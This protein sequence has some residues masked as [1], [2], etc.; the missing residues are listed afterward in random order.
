MAQRSALGKGSAFAEY[1]KREDMD[2]LENANKYEGPTGYFSFAAER[3]IWKDVQEE[4]PEELLLAHGRDIYVHKLPLSVY[5]PYCSGHSMQTLLSKGLVTST[6]SSRPARHMDT[7]VDHLANYLITLQHFFTGAQAASSVEWYSGPFIKSDGLS[8][9]GVKQNVQRLLFNL[10]YPSRVGMQ[11]PFTNFTISLDASKKMLEGDQALIGGQK[12][13][14]LGTYEVEA[15]SFVLALISLLME[16]DSAGAPFTFPIPTLMATAPML[17]DD[18]EIHDQVFKTASKKG[19]FYWLNT[20]VVDPDASFAMCCRINIDRN[21]LAF[22]YGLSKE[23][24]RDDKARFGGIWAI[25]DATGS[26]NATD[27]NLPRIAMEAPNESDFWELYEEKLELVR[28][29]E[30]WLRNRYTTYISRYPG[31]YWAIRTYLP[32]FPQNHFNTIGL[33]GL[34]E[35][36]SILMNKPDLWYEGNRKDWLEAAELMK[37]LVTFAVDHARRWMTETGVPWNVEEVPGESAAPKLALSDARDFARLRDFLPKDTDPIYSTSIAPYYGVVELPDR[38][39]IEAKVQK[40][41]TGGVMM[42]IFLGEEPDPEAL[43][44]LTK[45]LIQTDLVYWSYTPALTVCRACGHTSV[46]IHSTCPRCGSEDVEIWSRIIGYY[47][48]LKN[49]NPARQKEF[50][51]RNEYVL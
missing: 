17:W 48:P 3:A 1:V 41:F 20:R 46:G 12:A 14:P 8:F 33:L 22:A 15:R 18:P 7:F 21:E 37:K 32:E 44:S 45:K 43:A 50:W 10:N 36:A 6:V 25:P 11:T 47:R 30:E 16:G 4:F 26:V 29:A 34:P 23:E 5:L 2:V 39:E 31:F 28:A 9:Q 27:V 13:G 19:S 38:I 42:H 49:W 40:S 24:P 35:A 51:T